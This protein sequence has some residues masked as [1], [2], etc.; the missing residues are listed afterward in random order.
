MAARRRKN[1]ETVEI[2][3]GNVPPSI[4]EELASRKPSC[5]GHAINGDRDVAH[6]RDSGR[7]SA[8]AQRNRLH[9]RLGTGIRGS[10]ESSV[11]ISV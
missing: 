7:E 4:A 6:G 11:E 8:E 9:N 5:V 2:S 10:V 1:R 3:D